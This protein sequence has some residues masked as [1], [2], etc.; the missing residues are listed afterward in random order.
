MPE[1]MEAFFRAI[2]RIALRE[3]RQLMEVPTV[4]DGAEEAAVQERERAI[5]E[6][7]TIERENEELSRW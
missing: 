3:P 2:A 1:V 6:N 7:A 4:E 5:D